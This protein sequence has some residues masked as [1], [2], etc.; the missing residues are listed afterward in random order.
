M[1]RAAGKTIR[2]LA[3]LVRCLA[4]NDRA[5]CV[6]WS[7]DQVK[8]HKQLFKSLGFDKELLKR[9]DFIVGDEELEGKSDE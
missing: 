9:V 5:T 3:E 1:S 7:R 8:K 4:K 2:L 6:V